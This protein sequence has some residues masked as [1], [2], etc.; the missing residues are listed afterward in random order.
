MMNGLTKLQTSAQVLQWDLLDK[1]RP[2]FMF[3]ALKEDY[4]LL[5]YQS[6]LISLLHTSSPQQGKA[7]SKPEKWSE[8]L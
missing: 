4:P 1:S 5:S 8:K 3:L 6:V 7:K 2:V